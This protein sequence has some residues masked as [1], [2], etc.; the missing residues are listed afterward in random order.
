MIKINALQWK[1]EKLKNLKRLFRNSFNNGKLVILA[2]KGN[3]WVLIV[4]IHNYS[5]FFGKYSKTYHHMIQG[6]F[7]L[8]CCTLSYHSCLET[9]VV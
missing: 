4:N 5:A 1:I 9:L 2:L 3:D 7:C 8:G 6:I